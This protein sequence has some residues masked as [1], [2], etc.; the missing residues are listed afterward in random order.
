MSEPSRRDAHRVT[1]E[2]EARPHQKKLRTHADTYSVRYANDAHFNWSLVK[3]R[4]VT[5]ARLSYDLWGPATPFPFA[6]NGP[7]PSHYLSYSFR[8]ARPVSSG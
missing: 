8:A 4:L 2:S 6:F 1:L 5:D 3:P 7:S